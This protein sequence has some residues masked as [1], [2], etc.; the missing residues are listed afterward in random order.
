[1]TVEDVKNGDLKV[2]GDTPVDKFGTAAK[3]IKNENAAEISKIQQRE[4]DKE[5]K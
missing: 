2:T 1:M 3:I 4:K 5:G